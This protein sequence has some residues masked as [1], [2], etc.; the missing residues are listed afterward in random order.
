MDK[1]RETTNVMGYFEGR[2]NDSKEEKI[3]MGEGS[4][5][6]TSF[7]GMWL[8]DEKAYSESNRI[9]EQSEEA[10]QALQTN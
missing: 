4:A 2:T 6:R 5:A 7:F 9:L 8:R 3:V 10:T 1:V